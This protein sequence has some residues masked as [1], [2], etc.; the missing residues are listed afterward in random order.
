MLL[1]DGVSTLRWL[2]VCTARA[3]W[4]C[5]AFLQDVHIAL[6]SVLN[7]KSYSKRMQIV[8]S[9]GH[10]RVSFGAIGGHF[11]VSNWPFWNP[12]MALIGRGNAVGGQ[13]M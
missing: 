3:P 2:E 11:R 12:Q 4:I 8:A 10:N 9:G 1:Q 7:M 5:T 13:D 6:Y